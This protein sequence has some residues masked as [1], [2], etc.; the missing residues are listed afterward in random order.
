MY[1]LSESQ[2]GY[3]GLGRIALV[4]LGIRVRDRVWVRV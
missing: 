4:G 1:T 2:T 3:L